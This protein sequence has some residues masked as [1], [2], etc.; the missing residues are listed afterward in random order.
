[1]LGGI[2]GRWACRA[3]E[4]RSHRTKTLAKIARTAVRGAVFL[5]GLVMALDHVGVDVLALLAAA[6]ILGLAVGFGAQSLVKDVITGF[7]LIYE[8]A[9]AEGD[10]AQVGETTGVVERVGLRVSRDRLTVVDRSRIR[11]GVEASKDASTHH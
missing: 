7:F 5:V 4:R 3:L 2:L 11:A 8:G 9:I 6:G 10:I 1:M